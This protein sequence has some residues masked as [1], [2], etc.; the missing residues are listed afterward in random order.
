M[1]HV[2]ARSDALGQQRVA[3]SERAL[4]PDRDVVHAAEGQRA[5]AHVVDP[6]PSK[7]HQQIEPR[8]AV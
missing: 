1:P 4:G 7:R 3:D 2:C 5:G 6:E 8:V